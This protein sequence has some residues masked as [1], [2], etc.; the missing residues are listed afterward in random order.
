MGKVAHTFYYSASLQREALEGGG[1]T[2]GNR[3]RGAGGGGIKHVCPRIKI[4]RQYTS[5]D[6]TAL[7]GKGVSSMKEAG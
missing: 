7:S 1:I 5:L 3:G 2:K 4:I 6:Y